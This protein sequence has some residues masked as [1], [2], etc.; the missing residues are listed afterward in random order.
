MTTDIFEQE[1]KLEKMTNRPHAVTIVA[2]L[3][4][5]NGIILIAGAVFTIYFVPILVDQITDTFTVNMTVSFGL[6][7]TDGNEL[8]P[9]VVASIT[10]TIIT[11]AMITAAIGIA[12]GIACLLLAWGLFMA[13]GWSWIVTVILAIISIVFG[14]MAVGGGGFVNI[15]SIIISGLILYYLY[16]PTVKAYFGRVK[17]PR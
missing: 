12:I 8:S 1:E 9:E 17:I 2:I 7:L 15:I 13:K 4:I 6:N 16:R 10:D 5:I 11:I 14:L 3:M